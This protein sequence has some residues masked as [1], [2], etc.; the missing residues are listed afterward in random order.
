MEVIPAA[1]PLAAPGLIPRI[2]G[3]RDQKRDFEIS[4]SNL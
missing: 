3:A 2:R 4:K 1:K